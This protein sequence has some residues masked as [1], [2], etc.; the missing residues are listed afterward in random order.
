MID[1]SMMCRVGFHPTIHPAGGGVKPHPTQAENELTFVSSG[2][3][4][5]APKVYPFETK[6]FSPPMR[7]LHKW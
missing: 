6:R 5:R 2:I 7:R 3:S 4:A 1:L